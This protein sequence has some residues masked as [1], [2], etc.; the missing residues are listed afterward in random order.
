MKKVFLFSSRLRVYL[1]LIPVL[2]LL[3]IVISVHDTA[4]SIVKYYPLE[5]AL[6]ALAVLIVL[7]FFRAV[8][9]TK[10]E[11]RQIGLFTNREKA[12]IDEGKTLVFTLASKK[13]LTIELYG[14]TDSAPSLPWAGDVC[15]EINLFRSKTLGAARAVRTTLLCFGVC[16]EEADEILAKAPEKEISFENVAVRAE[17]KHDV[18][19]YRIRILKT[20]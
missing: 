20:I 12:M 5:I 15:G 18:L 6:G 4:T 16:P 8:L 10:D 11:I 14:G 1:S 7:F 9:I 13:R 17:K 19:I 2:T 3:G